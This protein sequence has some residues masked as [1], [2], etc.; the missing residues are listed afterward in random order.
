M[1]MKSRAGTI[2][3][4]Q[5]GVSQESGDTIFIDEKKHKKHTK[6]VKADSVQNAD[7]G[8]SE[9]NNP[10]IAEKKAADPSRT[11]E[12]I[13]VNSARTIF[14]IKTIFPFV[15]FTDEVITDE[16]KVTVIIGNFFRSGYLRSV[17]IQDISNVSVETSVF[18][19]KLTLIDRNFVQDRIT[20]S[21]LNKEEALKMRRII[22]GLIIAH[23]NKVDLADYTMQQVREYTEEIGRAREMEDIAV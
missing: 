13:A 3:R 23:E 14:R 12:G 9:K 17:M 2:F 11:L 20:V 19:A 8:E 16:E 18:F 4:R 15:L 21:Y 7:A 6:R 5:D 1:V 22:M 10:S